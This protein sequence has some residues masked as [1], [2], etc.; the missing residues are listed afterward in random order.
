[1]YVD[2]DFEPLRSFEDRLPG[3]SCFFAWE[4]QD[5]VANN[6]IMGAVPGHPFLRRLIDNLP[7][8]IL[9]RPG[10][11][12]SKTSG[13]RY[14][15]RELRAAPEDVT[16][17]PEAQFYP[18]RYGQWDRCWETFPEAFAVHH[19]RTSASAAASPRVLL[20][21]PSTPRFDPISG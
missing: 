4:H 13:P 11:R 9:S 6:A 2:T 17:F 15:T 20:R 10:Q 1:M 3:L 7:A 8:S 19:G 21:G 12:P 18:Y 16:V 5:E 14:L